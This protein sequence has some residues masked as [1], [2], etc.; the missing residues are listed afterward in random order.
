MF[1]EK[2]DNLLIFHDAELLATPFPYNVCCEIIDDDITERHYY[3]P[4]IRYVLKLP[5]QKSNIIWHTAN[6]RFWMEGQI[7][8]PSKITIT[9]CKLSS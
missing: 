7:S 3:T 8:H 5:N 6:G 1:K 4:Q 9:L 2:K